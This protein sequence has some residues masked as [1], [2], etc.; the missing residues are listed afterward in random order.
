[1][2]VFNAEVEVE[3]TL[4]IPNEP[5]WVI[6]EGVNDGIS[7]IGFATYHGQV[8]A[9]EYLTG[10]ALG[11][12]VVAA[13]AETWPTHLM[14]W[15]CTYDEETLRFTLGVSIAPGINFDF[16]Y[17]GS[18]AA[19]LGFDRTLHEGAA[20]YI[21]DF[22]PSGSNTLEI[23][24]IKSRSVRGFGTI[25]PNGATEAYPVTVRIEYWENDG[26]QTDTT[27]M[28]SNSLFLTGSELQNVG[29]LITGLVPGEAYLSR[30]VISNDDLTLEGETVEFT[31]EIFDYPVL[32]S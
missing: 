27:H 9:G 29:F 14:G 32:Q 12:A 11:D 24:D 20:F 26:G 13:L 19:E 16:T 1:V 31:T 10:Q 18:V 4:P 15:Y 2:I 5:R 23:K 22:I 17:P 30:L 25:N 8:P 6:E 7:W 3:F 28:F 21:S